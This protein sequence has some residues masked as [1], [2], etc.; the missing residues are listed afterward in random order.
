[1]SRRQVEARAEKRARLLRLPAV[2]RE[3]VH[4]V[5]AEAAGPLPWTAEAR[6]RLGRV[7]EGFMREA[8]RQEVERAARE[9][10]AA[11]VD[12]SRCEAVIARLRATMCPA[13]ASGPAPGAAPPG[14]GPA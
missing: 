12:L 1:V 3:L 10:G 8:T 5:A 2:T 13:A 11:E 4:E 6:A 9:A 7:P 14:E